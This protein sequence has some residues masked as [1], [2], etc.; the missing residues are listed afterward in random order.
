MIITNDDL[1]EMTNGD[2]RDLCDTL[3]DKYNFKT[4]NNACPECLNNETTED[5]QNG[6]IVCANCGLVIEFMMDRKPEWKSYE[7]NDNKNER[8]SM[9]INELLPMSSLGTSLNCRGRLRTLQTWSAMPYRERSLNN[10]F[11]KMHDLCLK[12]NILKCIEDDAKIFYK[13]LSNVVNKCDNKFIILRGDNRMSMVIACIFYAC[14]KNKKTRTVKELATL[15]GLKY[16]KIT[17]GCKEFQKIMTHENFKFTFG[18]SSPEDFVLRF[19]NKLNLSKKYAEQS[20]L[21]VKNIC[22]IKIA[23]VHTPFSVATCG[24]LL[25]AEINGLSHIDKKRMSSLVEISEVTITKTYKK[26]EKFKSILI[27]D[28]KIT[29]IIS[30]IE[31]NRKEIVV[32]DFILKKLEKAK[33]QEMI[34]HIAQISDNLDQIKIK[35]DFLNKEFETMLKK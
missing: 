13:T 34:D 15:S 14:R 29:K 20:L 27:D 9:P 1:C 28:S 17:H 19:C 3:E 6:I 7:N 23:D 26:I 4:N 31:N 30:T 10:V 24:I 11:K 18:I 12:G 16:T 21:I 32:P 33:D 8:C 35:I 25:M 5:S 2:M 22:R